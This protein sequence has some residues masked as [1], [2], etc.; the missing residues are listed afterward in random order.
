VSIIPG[1]AT[2]EEVYQVKEFLSAPIPTSLW[3][4][5]RSE[6]LLHPSAPTPH[7]ES[8]TRDRDAD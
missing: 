8:A 5:L 6:R 3:S 1:L 2:P 4:D 7:A